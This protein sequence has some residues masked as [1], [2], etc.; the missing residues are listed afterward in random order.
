MAEYG[1]SL[2]NKPQNLSAMRHVGL[3]CDNDSPGKNMYQ[4]LYSQE[5]VNYI[6][7]TVTKY[8][9]PIMNKAVIIPDEQIREMINSVWETEKGGDMANIY[10]KDT[11]DF[12]KNFF[13]RIVGITIQSIT[14]QIKNQYE[15]TVVN[16][17]LDIR[18]SLYGD[19]NECGLR[20]HS[21][22]KLREN[23]PPSMQFHMHY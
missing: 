7:Q 4:V 21:K 2:Q 19:F 9:Y 20:A 22:I 17:S 6:C 10:T 12:N 16:N 15:M 14:S 18:N 8:L 3:M 1:V 11:F 13:N 23:R 5:T